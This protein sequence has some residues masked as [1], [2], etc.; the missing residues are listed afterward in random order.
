MQKLQG[1]SF[2]LYYTHFLIYEG[3]RFAGEKEN[4]EIYVIFTF[5]FICCRLFTQEHT[6]PGH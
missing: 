1:S 5:A 4:V 3:K 2:T 6:L